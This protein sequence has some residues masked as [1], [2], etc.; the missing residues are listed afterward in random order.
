MKYNKLKPIY[1]SIINLKAFF[2][3]KGYV[4]A[5][6]LM[7]LLSCS[8]FIEVDPPKNILVSE[9]VFDDSATVESALASVYYNLREYGIVG[10]GLSADMGIYADE[11]DYY[12]SNSHDL[13]V[14]LH[15]M[16]PIN[17]KVANYWKNAYKLIYAVNDIIKGVDDSK[18]LGADEKATFKGQA[19]FMR[20]YLHFVLANIYGD[21]PLVTTTDY[22][23]NNTIGRT[24]ANEV[25][26]AIIADLTLAVSLLDSSDPTGERV[27]PN[28]AAGNALLARV[29]LYTENWEMAEATASLLIDGF[30]LETDLSK[31]FLKESTE[32]IWQFKSDPADTRNTHEANQF[33]IQAIPGNR[34]SL[35]NALLNSFEEGDLRYDDWIGSFTSAD[36]LTTLYFPYKYKALLSEVESL[37]YTIVFRLAEQYLIRAEARAQQ[38]DMAGAQEDLN[39]IRSRAGLDDTPAT[40][41]ASLLDAILHE[42]FVELFTEQGHRWFDLKR[43]GKAGEILGSVKPNWKST[44]VFWPI[45]ESELE[46]NPNLLPQNKGY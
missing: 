4:L 19:L 28:K 11:L 29:Y 8:D 41:K 10:Y 25:Y 36:G 44:D 20:A 6:M 34:Y 39:R 40:S 16:T 21:V 9:T 23:T 45:P 2:L 30:E 32:T 26:D 35:S 38:G 27:I 31:V 18:A 13:S 1:K 33:I 3:K 37:E 15:S 22:Q 12:A 7:V 46:I 24:A 5:I 14:Y 43:S 42:R 17:S